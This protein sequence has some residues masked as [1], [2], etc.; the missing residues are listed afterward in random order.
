M[1]KGSKSQLFIWIAQA[2]GARIV[3]RGDRAFAVRA[4]RPVYTLG[5]LR[6]FAGA[7]GMSHCVAGTV[8]RTR[9]AHGPFKKK[10]NPPTPVQVF[11]R[12]KVPFMA[13]RHSGRWRQAS[14]WARVRFKQS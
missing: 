1:E 2:A 4:R 5:P 10:K 11:G 12:D 9:P 13:E 14:K 3:T 6:L 8:A 7:K